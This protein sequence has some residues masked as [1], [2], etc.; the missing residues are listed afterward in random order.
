MDRKMLRFIGIAVAA[1]LVLGMWGGIAWWKIE[2]KV[3][4]KEPTT[5]AVE[6][7]V[8]TTSAAPLPDVLTPAAP[9]QTYEEGVYDDVW[10]I[11][12]KYIDEGDLDALLDTFP[13]VQWHEEPLSASK[14]DLPVGMSTFDDIDKDGMNELLVCDGL[15]AAEE[16]DWRTLLIFKYDPEQKTVRYCGGLFG[17]GTLQLLP[18]N[19]L[20]INSEAED[21]SYYGYYALE[22]YN[23]VK[24]FSLSSAAGADSYTLH[25]TDT[26]AGWAVEKATYMA[27]PTDI[28]F[29]IG[30]SEDDLAIY[31]AMN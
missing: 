20:L 11:Y 25:V 7:T 17:Y 26:D 24:K 5:V 2:G 23:L 9:A 22:G 29:Q 10:Q 31:E 19:G 14:S 3:A 15:Y 6:A 1:A 30:L 16:S 27:N 12:W 8:S 21:G 28:T 13:L 4:A 18:D